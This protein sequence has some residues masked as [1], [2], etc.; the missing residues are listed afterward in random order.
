MSE[1]G[2][3]FHVD[4]VD[5]SD[6]VGDGLVS[7]AASD[8]AIDDGN[9]GVTACLVEAAGVVGAT[10]VNKCVVGAIAGS[11]KILVGVATYS[12]TV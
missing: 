7:A 4:A 6:C 5:T 12:F 3:P 9:P 11:H 10:T 1:A 8:Y 2:N